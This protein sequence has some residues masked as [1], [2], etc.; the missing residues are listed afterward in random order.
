MSLLH[1]WVAA[2][3]ERPFAKMV[4]LSRLCNPGNSRGL[5]KLRRMHADLISVANAEAA[6]TESA[7]GK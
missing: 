5:V 4:H 6:E 2:H 1:H 3:T 7:P